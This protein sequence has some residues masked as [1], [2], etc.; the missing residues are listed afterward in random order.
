[1][2][3][4]YWMG[5]EEGFSVGMVEE[6]IGWV[7][8]GYVGVGVV[9]VSLGTGGINMLRIKKTCLLD[10]DFFL[11]AASEEK[12]RKTEAKALKRDKFCLRRAD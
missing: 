10:T 1:M 6:M 4:E 3:V 8:L 11:P 2:N 9:Y 5:G 12:I 7:G